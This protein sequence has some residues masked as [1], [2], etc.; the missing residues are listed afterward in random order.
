LVSGVL[1]TIPMANVVVVVV[2]VV[3]AGKGLLKLNWR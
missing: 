1:D 3:V 2:V